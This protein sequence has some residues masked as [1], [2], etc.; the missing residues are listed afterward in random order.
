MGRQPGKTGRH[1]TMR[2]TT[3]F[4]SEELVPGRLTSLVNLVQVSMLKALANNL[5]I[6]RA[7]VNAPITII[8]GLRDEIEQQKLIKQGYHPSDKSDHFFGRKPFTAGAADI[9]FKT[10][11][12]ARVIFYELVSRFDFHKEVIILPV[13]YVDVGQLIL[14]CSPKNRFYWIHIGN[15]KKLFY[16]DPPPPTVMKFKTSMNN[17]V[18][19]LPVGG[20]EK[21]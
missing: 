15:N 17:G 21:I 6:I 9:T 4:S 12:D 7:F 8:S 2:L 19:Y 5:E 14:E 10:P 1:K 20:F 18:T 13:G 11:E 3:H 16:K